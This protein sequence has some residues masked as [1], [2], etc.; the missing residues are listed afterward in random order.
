MISFTHM[1]I[2]LW[3]AIPLVALVGS[4][5]NWLNWRFLDFRVT[6]LLYY[7]GAFV[8]ESSHALACLVTGARIQEFKPFSSQPRVVHGRSRIPV[9]GSAI[10]SSAPIF[11]GIAFLYLLDRHVLGGAFGVGLV[12]SDW[13][14][15]LLAPIG[16]LSGINLA[17]WQGWAVVALILNAGAM[18]GPSFQDLKNMWVA[19]VVLFFLPSPAIL[20]G[21]C[22][23]ALALILAN[24]V[25]QATLIAV[26][27]LAKALK[28]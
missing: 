15:L 4:V 14:A 25:I 11:G 22:L 20:V 3:L 17:T 24:I 5:S 8:H 9:L 23:S 18:I 21:L 6:R 12:A 16:I 2:G 28:R 7:V 19:L 13:K 27:A 10:I 26:I 1:D